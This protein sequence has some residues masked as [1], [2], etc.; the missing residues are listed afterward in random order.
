M[1][2][3]SVAIVDRI[4]ASAPLAAASFSQPPR[5]R[6]KMGRTTARAAQRHPQQLL[7]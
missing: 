1:N 2:S 5:P 7:R 4:V 3:Q 6:K